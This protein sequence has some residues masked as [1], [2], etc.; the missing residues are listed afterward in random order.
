MIYGCQK[1]CVTLNNKFFRF[2][3]KQSISLLRS[4]VNDPLISG[5]EHALKWTEYVIRH[6][7]ASHLRSPAV[8]ITFTKYYL[9][10]I[11]SV[12][13]I[14]YLVSAIS[15]FFVIRFAFRWIRTKVLKKYELTGKFKA[16]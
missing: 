8:G 1:K 10:D 13:L 3:Y 6:Q 14:L 7:G 16:L 2:S 9:L 12:L 15:A 5:P 4:R 11:I